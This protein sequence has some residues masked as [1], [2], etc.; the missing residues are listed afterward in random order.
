M[1]ERRPVPIT[2]LPVEEQPAAVAYLARIGAL[3]GPVNP[4]PLRCRHPVGAIR[5]DPP[6]SGRGRCSLCP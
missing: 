4:S 1:R 6:G 3:P 2:A 5:E